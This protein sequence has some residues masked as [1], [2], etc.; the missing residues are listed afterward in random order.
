[1]TE[2]EGFLAIVINM[3]I[4][5]VPAIEDYWKTSWVAEVPFFSRVMPRDCFIS[6][7]ATES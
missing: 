6:S 4:I 2:L 3:G 1:M 5:S 7:R